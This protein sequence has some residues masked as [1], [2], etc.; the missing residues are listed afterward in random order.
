[1]GKAVGI[2]TWARLFDRRPSAFQWFPDAEVVAGPGILSSQ[3]FAKSSSV[4]ACR[5]SDTQRTRSHRCS[6]QGRPFYLDITERHN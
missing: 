5:Q 2:D 4:L 6:R 1:M 3:G